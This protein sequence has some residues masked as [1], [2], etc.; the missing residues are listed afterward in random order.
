[1][2]WRPICSLALLHSCAT[3]GFGVSG[4][5]R[6]D[7]SRQ[8]CSSLARFE[9]LPCIRHSCLSLNLLSLPLLA[10]VPIMYGYVL[11]QYAVD[12]DYYR[13]IMKWSRDIN[14]D[15]LETLFRNVAPSEQYIPCEHAGW[16]YTDLA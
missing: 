3:L 14:E 10:K 6:C 12:P 11:A 4:G 2:R 7:G 8:L 9:F 1:M 16:V 5:P 13:L 15:I